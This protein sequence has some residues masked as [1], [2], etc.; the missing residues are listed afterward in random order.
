MAGLNKKLVAMGI[1]LVMVTIIGSKPLMVNGANS[2]G[3]MCGMSVAGLKSCEPSV[4]GQ[5]PQVPPNKACCSALSGADLKCLCHLED[6]PLINFYS[7]D[8]DQA[9]ALP[10]LCKVVGSDWQCS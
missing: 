1:F 2:K 3:V 4:S 6:S 8:T 9:K 7:I 5:Q 10:A